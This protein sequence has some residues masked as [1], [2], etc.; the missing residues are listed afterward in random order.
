MTELKCTKGWDRRCPSAKGRKCTCRCGGRNHGKSRGNTQDSLAC[1]WGQIFSYLGLGLYK[2]RCGLKIVRENDRVT[3]I[4]TE[5]PDNP[6]TS[7]TNCVEEIATQVYHR[8]LKGTPI[9]KIRWIEHYPPRGEWEET[10]D[11]VSFDWDGETFSHPRW[12]RKTPEGE[13]QWESI[14]DFI[15]GKRRL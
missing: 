2:S 6:G 13:V 11:E 15:E 1:D 12:R 4:L 3:V 9:D 5:L 14:S 10:F 7:V 8:F